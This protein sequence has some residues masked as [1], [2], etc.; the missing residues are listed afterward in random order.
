MPIVFKL[1]KMDKITKAFNAIPS[2]FDIAMFISANMNSFVMI[3][4]F[5]DLSLSH[6]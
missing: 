5:A 4:K 6:L 2:R 1:M 3:L